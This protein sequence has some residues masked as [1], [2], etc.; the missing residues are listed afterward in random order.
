M[1]DLHP[2]GVR[3]VRLGRNALSELGAN[4]AAQVKP[5]EI[6]AVELAFHN[7]SFMLGEVVSKDGPRTVAEDFESALGQFKV[8]DKVLDVR[9]LEP[10]S[11]G[12]SHYV[13]TDKN[14][15]VFIEDI[16]KRKMQ[17]YLTKA[18][19]SRRSS[20]LGETVGAH[21]GQQRQQQWYVLSAEGKLDVLKLVSA[22]EMVRD[23]RD[24]ATLAGANN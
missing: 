21:S 16:R 3:S 2:K 10:V 22:N 23:R 17:D 8:G 24:L 13:Y 20:R 7:E 6:I 5:T 4:L 14:F 15:P 19:H 11:L 9:K 1:I 18:D 12:S